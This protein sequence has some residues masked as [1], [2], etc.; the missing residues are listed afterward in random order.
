[1]R[2]IGAHHETDRDL[3]THLVVLTNDCRLQHSRVRRKD[4]LDLEQL[5]LNDEAAH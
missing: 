5:G 3:V 2:D 1:M 4:L